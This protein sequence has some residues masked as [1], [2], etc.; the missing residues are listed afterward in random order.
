MMRPAQPRQ[1][2]AESEPTTPSS[3]RRSLLW[4]SI[5]VVVI[6]VVVAILVLTAGG[7]ETGE[8]DEPVTVNP[9]DDVVPESVVPAPT[10]LEGA[11]EGDSATFTW[12]NPDPQDGDLFLWSAVREGEDPTFETTADTAVTIPVADDGTACIEVAL[13]R[14]NARSSK[15]VEECAS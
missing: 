12:T 7:G 3:S 2:A 13:R 6:A 11:I 1:D 8:D 14:D 10:D 15:E 5:G 9:Q 4:S